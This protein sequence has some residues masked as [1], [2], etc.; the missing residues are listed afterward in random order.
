VLLSTRA[1]RL[2]S[3]SHTCDLGAAVGWHHKEL[4][5]AVSVNALLERRAEL[6]VDDSHRLYGVAKAEAHVFEDAT[7]NEDLQTYLHRCAIRG[8]KRDRPTV[9]PLCLRTC[10]RACTSCAGHLA[11]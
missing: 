10:A 11:T 8:I 3:R 6:G 9:A 5:R 1:L 2:S 4:R 7:S